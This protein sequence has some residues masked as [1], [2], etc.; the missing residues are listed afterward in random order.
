MAGPVDIQEVRSPEGRQAFV[1]LPWAILG[2]DPCWVP[3]LRSVAERTLDPER[4]PFFEHGE[5]TLFLA[6]RG[7][8]AVG[9]I[10]A[11]IDHA[12]NE[13]NEAEGQGAGF[14]GFFETLNDPTV[15]SA[16]FDAAAQHL[17]DRGMTVLRGP[18]SPNI[19][20]EIGLLVE[21]FDSMPY[22][23]MPYNPAYY[24]E[25]V[26]EAGFAKH[27]D[28][29][30]YLIH[31]ERVA[32][33]LPTMRRL[34]RLAAAIQ[35]R[36]PGL[37]VRSLD[38][39][40]YDEEVAT[41]GRLFN[42]AR[43]ENWGFVPMT[44]A[45]VRAMARDMR[46]IADP[47]LI[48]I[49]ELH[50]EPVGCIMGIPDLN[51]IL[52]KMNGRLWPFG[53]LHLLLGKRRIHCARVFGVGTLPEYRKTG[54]T[55]LLINELRRHS[56]AAGYDTGE[57]SWVTEDNIRSLRLIEQAIQPRRYKTYRIYQRPL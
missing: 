4:H 46:P 50:G 36:Q 20:G 55:P 56:L 8:E 7:E 30:A 16:L 52:K 47:V 27:K 29:Y 28:L 57:L 6:R 41:L 43:S 26:E 25:R 51:P 37:T 1:E 5:M 54:V 2:D 14:W 18:F 44:D 3:P 22:V 42:Q 40:R 19:N 13:R 17:R 45:E 31:A 32:S 23:L 39:G 48:H 53:W 35:R 34:E 33:E 11:I 15:S 49:A 9:R 10:A 12:H 21:G 24:V 38:L